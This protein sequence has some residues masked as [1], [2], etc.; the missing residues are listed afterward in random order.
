MA[1]LKRFSY[2]NIVEHN[3]TAPDPVDYNGGGSGGEGGGSGGDSLFIIRVTMTSDDEGTP[4]K[5]F[6]E[7]IHAYNSGQLPVVYLLLPT[8]LGDMEHIATAYFSSYA[9]DIQELGFD[10]IADI[11]VY[12]TTHLSTFTA[13]VSIAPDYLSIRSKEW[14]INGAMNG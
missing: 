11:Q 5:S 1:V 14:L 9:I 13:H 7:I 12:D 4:D 10:T 6:D 2:D 3:P 8:E